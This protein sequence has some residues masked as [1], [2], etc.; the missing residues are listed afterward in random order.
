MELTAKMVKVTE[1]LGERL[2]LR[3]DTPLRAEKWR[4]GEME[5]SYISRTVIAENLSVSLDN[6]NQ[7]ME[8][9][10]AQTERQGNRKTDRQK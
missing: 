6:H 7:T 3:Y 9:N 4:D 8:R 5:A 1:K 10:T 2:R